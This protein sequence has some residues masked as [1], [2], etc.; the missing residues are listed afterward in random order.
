MVHGRRLICFVLLDIVFLLLLFDMSKAHFI[1][2]V[3]F[4][5]QFLFFGGTNFPSVCIFGEL[6]I[7]FIFIVFA[8]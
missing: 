4:G 3:V 8:G 6:H 7:P 2:S 1:N 5:V